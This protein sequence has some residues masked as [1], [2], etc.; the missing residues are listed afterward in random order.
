MDPKA[1]IT[2]HWHDHH[3][4]HYSGPNVVTVGG[5]VLKLGLG[6][7]LVGG[8]LKRVAK[9]TFDNLS[10]RHETHHDAGRLAQEEQPFLNELKRIGQFRWDTKTAIQLSNNSPISEKTQTAD[11][12]TEEFQLFDLLEAVGHDLNESRWS[13]RKARVR[14]QCSNA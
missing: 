7:L 9:P 10:F 1:K 11:L 2:P 5:P 13:G 6:Q 3:L 14:G 12:R 8:Y 4:S